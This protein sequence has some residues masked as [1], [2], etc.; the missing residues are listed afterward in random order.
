M[1]DAEVG[2]KVKDQRGHLIQGRV[3]TLMDPRGGFG[4]R[5]YYHHMMKFSLPTVLF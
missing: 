1:E 3:W 5:P 4:T 2:Q